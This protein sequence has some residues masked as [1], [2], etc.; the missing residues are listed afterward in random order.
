MTIGI[1]DYKDAYRSRRL[2]GF[3]FISFNKIDDETYT[4][5]ATDAANFAK[6]MV[7]SFEGSKPAGDVV[8]FFE[9]LRIDPQLRWDIWVSSEYLTLSYLVEDPKDARYEHS[10][11]SIFRNEDVD[12][13]LVATGMDHAPTV[14]VAKRTDI[15]DVKDL[16]HALSSGNPNYA[17][18][19]SR[20]ALQR[21]IFGYGWSA[22]RSYFYNAVA[23]REG[24]DA[25][26]APLRD[27]FCESCYRIDYP[28]QVN[29]LLGALKSKSQEALA[30][31]LEPTGRAKFAMRLPFFTAYCISKV[32]SRNSARTCSFTQCKRIS[33]CRVFHNLTTCRSG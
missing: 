20:S 2:K 23:Q 1:D 28:S 24:A 21:M 25:Y 16:V 14:T 12:R 15:K 10:V 22:E 18:S 13:G 31:I 8:S 9:A 19:D 32:D 11:D 5:L 6:S 17:G 26:L 3:D 4:S 7:F 27:T 30:S 33:D 29:A